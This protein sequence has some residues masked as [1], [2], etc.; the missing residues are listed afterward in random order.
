MGKLEKLV[1]P[2]N[3]TAFFLCLLKGISFGIV[4]VLF[5]P[6]VSFS[7]MQ[8]L[9]YFQET[10]HELNVYKINGVEKGKTLLIIGGIQGNEPG[11]YLAADLYVDMS[12]EKGNLIVVPR[13]N[14]YS[15][16]SN[17]RGVNGDM[18]RQFA[19]FSEKD[20]DHQRAFGR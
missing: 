13:A 4:L 18:N 14:F 10:E 7:A 9:T 2:N 15:I 20:N 6:D 16:I 11:G 19:V 3:P 1:F 12:L 5:P 8:R 17:Q